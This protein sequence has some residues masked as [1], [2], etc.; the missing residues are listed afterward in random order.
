[1]NLEPEYQ[2]DIELD[3][4]VNKKRSGIMW[5]FII[6]IGVFLG[7]VLSYG[8]YEAYSYWKLKMVMEAANSALK[9]QR[10]KSAEKRKIQERK[11][12]I[13][14]N[15]LQQQKIVRQLQLRK[16]SAINSQ[17][18]KTCTFWRQQV[19]KENTAQNRSNRDLACAR[20]NGSFR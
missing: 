1:M 13:Y 3:S 15:Q 16:E 14:Q 6:V 18:K 20:L 19:N 4:E 12:L 7:N 2:R 9:E 8:T 11:N 5:V 17:L 10:I